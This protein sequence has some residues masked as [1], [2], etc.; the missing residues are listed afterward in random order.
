MYDDAVDQVAERGRAAVPVDALSCRQLRREALDQ[1][2]IARQR[3]G[4]QGDQIWR[5]LDPRQRDLQLSLLRH[6][7]QQAIPDRLHR[8]ETLGQR[9]DQPVDLS[10]K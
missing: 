6:E 5:R 8:H 3:G 1:I 4:M 9:V 2:E 7:A 10:R